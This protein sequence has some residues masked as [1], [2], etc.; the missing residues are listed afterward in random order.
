M[1]AL[2]T[3]NVFWPL[4]LRQP[5][6][7]RRREQPDTNLC[8]WAEKAPISSTEVPESPIKTSNL[9]QTDV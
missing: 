6:R 3:V 9:L 4:R 2:N 5:A 1:G 7:L 8:S